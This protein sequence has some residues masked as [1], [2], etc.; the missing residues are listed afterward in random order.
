MSSRVS[1]SKK[2]VRKA[3]PKR[4]PSKK[5]SRS[6][7]K[8]GTSRKRAPVSLGVTVHTRTPAMR[9]VGRGGLR[10]NHTEFFAD[11]GT[12]NTGFAL[13]ANSPYAIN[14]GN[15]SMFPWL[16]DIAQRFETYKFHSLR[17]RYEPMVP[18]TTGGAIYI[19]VDFDATDPAPTSK[20]N[21]LSYKGA[22]RAPVWENLVCHCDLKDMSVIKERNTLNQLPPPGQDPRLY[23]VGNL[24][25]AFEAINPASNGE[26]WVDYDVE[27]QTP[28]LTLQDGPTTINLYAGQGSANPLAGATVTSAAKI[29]LASLLTESSGVVRMVLNQTGQYLYNSTVGSTGTATTNE[30]VLSVL[31]GAATVLSAALPFSSAAGSAVG[32]VGKTGDIINVTQAPAVFGITTPTLAS[33]NIL[34]GSKILLDKL[35]PLAF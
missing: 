4:K 16:T 28:Q 21:M 2:G 3:A 31:S 19:A 11:I 32:A 30:D 1:R 20:L 15:E 5:I 24:W 26:L 14:P 6:S 10:V 18:T 34:A 12:A 35:A 23:N 7:V 9:T 33:N 27:F 17:F 22:A 13:T 8:T 29:P 25:V